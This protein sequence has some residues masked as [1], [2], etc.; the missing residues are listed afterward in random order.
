LQLLNIQVPFFFKNI[1]DQLNVDFSAVSASGI[2][3]TVLTVAGT[4]II[5]CSHLLSVG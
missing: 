4:A 1:I 3:A 5:G 2:Q